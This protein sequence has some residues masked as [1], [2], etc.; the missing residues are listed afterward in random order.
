MSGA[1]LLIWVQPETDLLCQAIE[2]SVFEPPFS[3]VPNEDAAALSAT[4]IKD[5]Q[6]KAKLG[7][8]AADR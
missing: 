7:V 4:E 8:T 2:D 6:D 5:C 1:R 3:L